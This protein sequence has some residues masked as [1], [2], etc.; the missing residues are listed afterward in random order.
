MLVLYKFGLGFTVKAQK[1]MRCARARKP[2]LLIRSH[3]VNTVGDS[4]EEVAFEDWVYPTATELKNW[5][6]KD[7]VP[8][9]FIE[10]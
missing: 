5:H 4:E 8:I 9:S 2:P 7:F 10:E 6:A 3:E 1:E